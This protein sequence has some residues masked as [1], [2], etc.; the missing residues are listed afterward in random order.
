[1]A[2]GR[3]TAYRPVVDIRTKL[4]FALVA[5]ALGSM[6]ALGAILYVSADDALREG[7]LDQIDALAESRKDAVQQVVSGWRD[8]TRLIAS[9]TQLRE[10]LGGWASRPGPQVAVR[11]GRILDDVR[12]AVNV[13]ESVMVYDMAGSV[14]VG[15]GA[16]EQGEEPPALDRLGSAGEVVVT[17]VRVGG[18]GDLQ[19]TLE[20][21]LYLDDALVGSLRVVLDARALLDLTADRTG[22]GT[23]GETLLVLADRD[24]TPHV[25]GG[26][27]VYGADDPVVALAREGSDGARWQDLRDASGEPVWVAARPI[28]E[29]GWGVAVKVDAAEGRAPVL[30]FR[31]RSIRSAV[32]L[33]A[34]AILLGALLGLH[35]AKPIHD[36]AEVAGRVREGELHARVRVHAGDE[37]G[38][39]SRTF[40][41]MADEL[42]RQMT[43]LREFERFFD[44]SLDM[45]CIARTDGFFKR[46]NPAFGRILGWSD[47]KLLGEPFL[48]FVH[49]DDVDATRTVLR[50]L[51]E[52]IPT[53][54]FENRYRRVDGSYRALAWTTYPEPETG[55]LYAIARDVTEEKREREERQE[56]SRRLERAEAELR[57]GP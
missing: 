23:S 14:V 8:R 2:V 12:E 48:S 17:G 51:G 28:P 43:Q 9:R 52:G 13:V 31:G 6:L 37:I 47:E 41:Q 50:K 3:G 29:L 44:V 21:G 53:L 15:R 33:A 22:L 40:N 27:G 19:A 32:A 24:G 11:I 26:S 4:V 34:F 1:M 36:L 57:A 16:G 49:P 5:V 7:R 20:T 45:M 54:S 56:L 46:V 42:E 10:S 30:A 55:L 25:L 38:L 35:F 39:L 18:S